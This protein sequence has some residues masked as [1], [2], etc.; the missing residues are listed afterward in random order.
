MTNIENQLQFTSEFVSK[1]LKDLFFVLISFKTA[2]NTSCIHIM[3]SVNENSAYT[4][5]IGWNE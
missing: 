4:F 1:A 2:E 5:H 3:S